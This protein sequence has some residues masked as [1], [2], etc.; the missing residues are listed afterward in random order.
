MIVVLNERVLETLVDIGFTLVEREP[1]IKVIGPKILTKKQSKRIV[2]SVINDFHNVHF[3]VKLRQINSLNN[4]DYD[5]FVSYRGRQFNLNIMYKQY[6]YY[7]FFL[8]ALKA[9]AFSLIQVNPQWA[10][11]IKE[12]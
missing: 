2:S 8:K 7:T 12:L 6:P 5:Y 1:Q 9:K 4:N 11:Y 3:I 10:L